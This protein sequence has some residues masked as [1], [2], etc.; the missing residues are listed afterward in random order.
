M[1]NKNRHHSNLLGKSITNKSIRMEHFVHVLSR[2][3]ILEFINL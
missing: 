3:W 1:M 2:T